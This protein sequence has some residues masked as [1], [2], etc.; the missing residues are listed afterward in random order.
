VVVPS[1]KLKLALLRQR[2]SELSHGKDRYT[3]ILSLGPS[4]KVSARFTM[5]R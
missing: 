5:K 2:T 1:V 4:E 3:V